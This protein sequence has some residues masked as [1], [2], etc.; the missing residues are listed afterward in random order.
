MSKVNKESGDR[1][2]KENKS[3]PIKNNRKMTKV[4]KDLRNVSRDKKYLTS[5]SN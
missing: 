1:R 4:E 2:F 5:T 3:L